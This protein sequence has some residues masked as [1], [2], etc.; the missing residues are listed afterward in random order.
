M[1]YCGGAPGNR[2]ARDLADLRGRYPKRLIQQNAPLSGAFCFAKQYFS[3]MTIFP[4]SFSIVALL[5]VSVAAGCGG[6]GGSSGGAAPAPAPGG[7]DGGSGGSGGNGEGVQV[8]FRDSTS[9]LG[10]DYFVPQGGGDPQDLDDQAAQSGGLALD[11]I[12]NDG[13][14]ELYIAPGRNEK[15]RLLTF[16]GGRFVELPGNNGIAPAEMDRAGYFVD[17]DGDGWKD[18]V[19]IQYQSVEVFM[20]DQ[21]GGFVEATE[22]SGI[23]HERFTF[24]MAAADYDLDGDLD[25]FFAHWGGVV[26]QSALTEYLWEND[27]AG[28]FT[29]V[30][31]KVMI[32]SK[33]E[34]DPPEIAEL[35]F[36]PTFADIDNDGYPDML[37]ASDAE[38]SQVLRNEAGLQ[39]VDATTD[40]ISDKNG[41]GGAV[42]DYDRDGDLDWFVSSIHNLTG[43]DVGTD[44]GNRMY[45]N[46]DGL[47]NF[48]DVTD[49][50]GLRNADWGWGS[51]FADFDNDGHV[52]LL[53]TNGYQVASERFSDDA[54]RLF[55][56][57]GEGGFNDG[58][59][60]F[61]IDH[62]GQGRGVV[63]ADIDAD[64]RIDVLISNNGDAPNA[65]LNE[66]NDDHHYLAIDLV[67]AG[68]NRDAIGARVT[69]TS[70]SGEQTQE[71]QLGTWYLSQG[72]QT[73]HFGLGEDEVVTRIDV[74]WP[75]AP[76]AERVTSNLVDVAVDQ[77]IVISAPTAYP[78]PIPGGGGSGLTHCEGNGSGTSFRNVTADL[79]LCYDAVVG[80]GAQ[81]TAQ[82]IGGG[83]ALVDID[84]D[85]LL[86]LFVAHG[87]ST[88]GKLYSFDGTRFIARTNSGL[89]IT[90]MDMAGYFVDLD[91]DGWKDF[92]SA[93]YDGIE[94]FIN[95]QTG[96]FIDGDDATSISHSR[97][98]YSMAAGDHDNDGDLDL[99][100]AHWGTGRI[101]GQTEYL[102]VN[103]RGGTFTDE[104]FR[105][106]IE[107]GR[108]GNNFESEY[109][110]T[111]LLSDIDADGDVDLL[112]ASDFELSQVLEN[113]VGGD[114]F[115]DQTTDVISDENGMGAAV[116]DYD[117]DGDLDW[118]VSSIWNP[119]AP[120]NGS[121]NRLY[122]NDGLGN[123]EDVTDE[124]GVREGDWGW[125]S[126]FADF[127]N[128]GYADIFHT[129]GHQSLPQFENDPSRLFMSNGD[130][131][132]T[133]RAAQ[134]GIAHTD[135]GRGVVCADYDYDGKVDIFI[136]NNGTSPTIFRNEVDNG[137][138][139][140]TID[141][142]GTDAN[143]EAV[144][145]RVTVTTQ[146][147]SQVQE[148]YLGTAYLSQAPS[149]L[150]FG[151][152]VDDQIESIDIAWP[153]PGSVVSRVE[154]VNVDQRVEIE[155]GGVNLNLVVTQGA[156]GGVYDIGDT[157]PVQANEPGEGYYFS[158]WSSEGGGTFADATRADTQFIMPGGTVT[159]TAN[160]VPGVAPGADVS[161]ARR[162]NEVLL[163]AIRNDFAR[164]TVHARNL[165][166]T[167]SVMYDAWSAY[168]SVEVP[169]L[170]GRTRAG[171]TCDFAEIPE[172]ADVEASRSTALSYATYRLI[173][174]RFAN[175]PG[176]I[177]IS[178][179][180]EALMGA[181]GLDVGDEDSDYAS[182]SAAALGNHIAQC[183]IDFGYADGANEADDYVNQFYLP[184]NEPLEPAEPGNPNLAGVDGDLNRWQ[185]LS[186]VEFIDQSGN[187]INDTPEFLGPEWGQVVPFA[188]S[189][190]DLTT[191]QR[192]GFDYIVYHDPGPPPTFDGVLADNYK[193][194][195]SL[196]SIWSSHLDPSDGVMIDISPAS[197]GNITSY[198][199]DFTDYD[200]FYNTL[201]GG[202]GSTGYAANPVTGLPYTE[203]LVPRGDYGRVL[204][205]FWADGPDSETPPGHWFVIANGVNDHPLLERRMGGAGQE[206]DQLEW[207]VKTYF[208]LGGAM[209][210]S[211]VTA[212]GVKGWYDYI[213][214]ISSIRAMADR[215]QSNDPSLASYHVDGIGL[216]PGYIELVESGD[217]LAGAS[218]EHVGKIKVLAWRGPDYIANPDTDEAGVGWILAEHWWPY[219]RPSF[220]TPPFAGY[221]SGHSTYSR[222]AAEVLTALTGDPFFPGGM[223]GFEIT[224]DEFLVFEDGPS[225]SMT[226]EWA[227]YRDA[228]DQCS[229]SRIWGGIHPPPDDLPGRLIGI[230]IGTDAFDEATTFFSGTATP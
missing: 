106:P 100:F 186:L 191:Y 145:A 117:R 50:T 104:S 97:A 13:D 198:P 73:L 132:F 65:Y 209:H 99:F 3:A 169:W 93:Q 60:A 74:A 27:G 195:F 193:W 57:D 175:S 146:S 62:T 187:P 121:G 167:S 188:L 98:T 102:W 8:T 219:Q 143:S 165:F 2:C 115:V 130:G 28:H 184:V 64:G 172:P 122:R 101:D 147:G 185:P 92:L 58:A 225:A 91:G 149:T 202:D 61:G 12:D 31:D 32:T 161:V 113:E 114:L 88:F 15:G 107:T 81:T 221:V 136:A 173:R 178:R 154:N 200:T 52:D 45:R 215:G 17:L 230:E 222:A 180:A 112:L 14:L 87:H 148:V 228:S 35:S 94:I 70:A 78:T 129:N 152:G 63:C 89:D 192:D 216:E 220:V 96:S 6:D 66:T 203:Q 156:G 48:E 163:Q 40:V 196:V 217:P 170:L 46:V 207:E 210:D 120:T 51:C 49:L 218:D 68:A 22:A 24:S 131:T 103:Q 90:R 71:V 36:T 128:D 174:H 119:G 213:R 204:A 171:V 18:F 82:E 10:L 30:S 179:D 158:H 199:T 54:T 138:H 124:A 211:A 25:L 44:T 206:L 201:Q 226:L 166:H 125:G 7:G 159:I 42:A 197:L 55:M 79:G 56:A 37:L 139:F 85:G 190:D 155:Q 111:P 140:I 75:G 224:Q 5:A 4:R 142:V 29:D 141:L 223:S 21:T 151:L 77:R 1:G 137:N 214:P 153:G 26:D 162:W 183:Y 72:P 177:T 144:G 160:Y 212:W 69:I 84:K 126:C 150:H 189:T 80:D 176:T 133:E 9:D 95:D 39:F 110:F 43:D 194:A 134:M 182:G 41:M 76:S 105:I 47:G 86:E 67:G 127:D 205:E 59:V 23:T 38:S 227:T 164:P 34:F 208:T 16:D 19:S 118:F 20:S 123:F 229:L 116:A 53:V 135:Q 11:D 83:L 109:S 157:V 181:L 108:S 33:V 168:A